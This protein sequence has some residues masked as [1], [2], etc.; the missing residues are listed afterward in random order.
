MS[1][2]TT[3]KATERLSRKL[4]RA[5]INEWVAMG[6][7]DQMGRYLRFQ[8]G[9]KY[10]RCVGSCGWTLKEAEA[11]IDQLIREKGNVPANHS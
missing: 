6:F 9:G 10:A 4:K 8:I 5:G 3:T 1:V 7:G 2:I 11:I